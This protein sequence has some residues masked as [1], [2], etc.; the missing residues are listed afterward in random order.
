MAGLSHNSERFSTLLRVFL[1]LIESEWG[2]R[3][4][5]MTDEEQGLFRRAHQALGR[6]N[7]IQDGAA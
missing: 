2:E 5:F 7:E 4:R 1:S 6:L 3:R